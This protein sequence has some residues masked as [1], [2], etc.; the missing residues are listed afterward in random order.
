MPPVNRLAVSMSH[1]KIPARKPRAPPHA[2]RSA[3][4]CTRDA[5]LHFRNFPHLRDAPQFLHLRDAPQSLHLRDAP[6]SLPL[7]DAPQ[8]LHSLLLPENTPADAFHP[9]PR[10]LKTHRRL[11]ASSGRTERTPY[12]FPASRALFFLYIMQS[13]HTLPCHASCTCC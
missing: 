2:S 3:A 8:S 11:P 12:S 4:S 5:A 9:S 6:Q 10:P 13:A 1:R 7:R